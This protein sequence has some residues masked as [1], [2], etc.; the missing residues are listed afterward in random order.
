MKFTR[1][2]SNGNA[3][4]VEFFLCLM[5]FFNIYVMKSNIESNEFSENCTNLVKKLEN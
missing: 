4:N 5:R 2:I 3:S 1:N